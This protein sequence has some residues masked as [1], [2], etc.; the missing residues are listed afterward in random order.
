MET[1]D[2]VYK[3]IYEEGR[4]SQ[5]PLEKKPIFLYIFN[6]TI[7]I[8]HQ[9]EQKIEALVSL[10][11]STVS[12]VYELPDSSQGL[13]ISPAEGEPVFLS[14]ANERTRKRCKDCLWNT[15][16]ALDRI[17]KKDDYP[18]PHINLTGITDYYLLN[19]L[20]YLITNSPETQTSDNPPPSEKLGSTSQ[21]DGNNSLLSATNTFQE[22]DEELTYNSSFFSSVMKS[23]MYEGS[24]IGPMQNL[25]KPLPSYKP[26]PAFI[27][28]LPFPTSHYSFLNF[29]ERTTNPSTEEE[30]TI[31]KIIEDKKWTPI[32]A[33]FDLA[34]NQRN[35]FPF[36]KAEHRA[37]ETDNDKQDVE[38]EQSTNWEA[39]K[40]RFSDENEGYTP[41]TRAQFGSKRQA[42]PWIT[43]SNPTRDTAKQFS[44]AAERKERRPMSANPKKRKQI[45]KQIRSSEPNYTLQQSMGEWIYVGSV[46][47]APVSSPKKGYLRKCSSTGDIRLALQANIVTHAEEE[48]HSSEVS[49]L[50]SS[51]T[52]QDESEGELVETE[53]QK[54]DGDGGDQK[55][56]KIKNKKKRLGGSK[57]R[58]PKKKKCEVRDI[59]DFSQFVLRQG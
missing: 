54:E 34:M 38:N 4:L 3:K 8:V 7:A 25:T 22:V 51:G 41:P 6:D 31:S 39:P 18:L 23:L 44:L 35:P 53:G 57:R 9:S 42:R 16:A 36:I 2:P 32:Q 20:F 26:P 43:T 55:I 29:P 52:G 12:E 33:N 50:D 14:F 13:A 30:N 49:F 46:K 59:N 19:H 28:P 37:I 58:V 48:T 24:V 11:G 56:I 47:S 21:S 27:P 10:F 5:I 1:Q 15:I 45:G 17:N 40:K